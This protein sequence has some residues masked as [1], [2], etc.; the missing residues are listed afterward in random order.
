MTYS[1]PSRVSFKQLS[2]VPNTLQLKVVFERKYGI[3]HVFFS[4]SRK[5]A[6]G[7]AEGFY[8]LRNS[9]KVRVAPLHAFY[10]VVAYLQLLW[11]RCVRASVYTRKLTSQKKLN[12]RKRR[13]GVCN[14]DTTRVKLPSQPRKPRV[15][16]RK[17]I[18][19]VSLARTMI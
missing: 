7:F 17:R 8:H 13:V 15:G 11:F 1:S 5:A 3:E 6:Y 12:P 9:R 16:L 18:L 19:F 2:S 10:E 14:A 4:R